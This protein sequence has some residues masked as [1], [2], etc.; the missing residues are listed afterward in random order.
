[1]GKR[2]TGPDTFFERG[3]GEF[4][5]FPEEKRGREDTLILCSM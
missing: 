2:K 1:M 4:P 3:K 5:A